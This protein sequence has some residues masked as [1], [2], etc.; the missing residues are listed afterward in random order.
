MI[1]KEKKNF[2]GIT[3]IAQAAD[4]IQDIL[5]RLSSLEK[6]CSQANL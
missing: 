6:T 1:Q 5:Q 3:Q 2:L 4:Y